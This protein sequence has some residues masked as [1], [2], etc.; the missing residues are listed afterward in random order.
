MH[1]SYRGIAYQTAT[2]GPIPATQPPIPTKYR[3]VSY[4]LHS[5]S[6]ISA[7]PAVTLQYRGVCYSLDSQAEQPENAVESMPL[8]P[9]LA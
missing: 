8:Q 6:E 1:L 9:A 7:P 2:S 4:S 3:G 5:E